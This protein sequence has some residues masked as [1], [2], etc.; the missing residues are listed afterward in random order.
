MEP[1]LGAVAGDDALDV[2]VA[3]GLE[4]RILGL[5]EELV[6]EG[7]TLEAARVDGLGSVVDGGSPFIILYVGDVGVA[8]DTLEGV[9]AEL[10]E[11]DILTYK[12]ALTGIGEFEVGSARVAL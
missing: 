2:G 6:G 3:A 7:Y 9:G 8:P 10:V 12:L 4:L 1:R 11:V 5:E